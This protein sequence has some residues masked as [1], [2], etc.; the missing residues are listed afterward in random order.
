[1]L[2]AEKLNIAQ[3]TERSQQFSRPTPNC[4]SLQLVRNGHS[5]V[6]ILREDSCGKALKRS[7]KQS[8][9]IYDD[10]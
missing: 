3:E 6:D 1:M 9:I 2:T 5:T 10:T 7:S 4:A 8:I